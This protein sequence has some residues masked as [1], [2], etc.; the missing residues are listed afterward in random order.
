MKGLDAKNIVGRASETN[1]AFV[2]RGLSERPQTVQRLVLD[3]GK[4]VDK[5]KPRIF[6]SPFKS[7]F[8]ESC[9]D[10]SA[11]VFV[12][13]TTDEDIQGHFKVTQRDS[14]AV[15]Y[16]IPKAFL[17]WPIQ[18]G[19]TMEILFFSDS[20]FRSGSNISVTSGGL[21]ISDGSNVATPVPAT[22]GLSA[23]ILLP[24][25]PNRKVSNFYNDGTDVIYVGDATVTVANGMPV[26]VGES[27]A[28]RNA[29]ALYAISA[30][31]SQKVRIMI[32]GG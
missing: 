30:T 20:E 28:Y 21:S 5:E 12:R 10:P 14:W 3:L 17:H 2:E 29:S 25:D 23:A 4:A 1:Q 19:K 6:N 24:A 9:S 32:E 8:V 18:P 16:Q 11:F 26:Q 22:V 13:P 7:F 15:E 27:K 31:A